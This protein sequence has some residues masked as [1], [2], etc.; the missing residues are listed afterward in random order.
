MRRNTGVVQAVEADRH[1][2]QAGVLQHAGLAR[3]QRA[4]GGEGEFRR[5]AVHGAQRGQL[6]DQD[7]EVLAQQRLAAG[8]A[9][10]V[11]AMRHELPAPAG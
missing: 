4:V 9:D 7:L 10:L 6:A 3:Q 8:Q 11:H 2:L 5:R 1:A